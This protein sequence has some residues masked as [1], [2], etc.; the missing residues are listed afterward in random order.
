MNQVGHISIIVAFLLLPPSLSDR[1]SLSSL[2]KARA[3][4]LEVKL[5]LFAIQKTTS[6]EK[7]LAQRYA[8]SKYLE[9]V[10]S[11]PEA[12]LSPLVPLLS[13]M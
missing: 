7:M 13:A 6:F 1:T 9:S 10:S 11:F 12:D 2:M 4:E 3:A 8:G 5:L